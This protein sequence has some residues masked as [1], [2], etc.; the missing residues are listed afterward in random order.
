[1]KKLLNLVLFVLVALVFATSVN[2]VY[3][4]NKVQVNGVD[5][6]AVLP[7]VSPVVYVERG[8]SVN[9]MAQFANTVDAKDVRVK[10]WIGGYEFGN[11]EYTTGLFDVIAS[12]TYSKSLLLKIPDDLDATQ[13]Y[14]LHVSVYDKVTSQEVSYTLRIARQRHEL[15]FVDIIFNPGL[16]VRNDQPLFVTVRVE[17]LGNKDENDV[18]VIAAIPELGISQRTFLSDLRA[19]DPNDASQEH[20]SES[21]EA[22]FLDLSDVA[23][24][25]YNVVV[26]VEYNRGHDFIEK[27]FPLTVKEGKGRVTVKEELVVDAAQKVMDIKAGQG[28]VYKVSL[29]NLGSETQKLTLEVNGV[30]EWGTARADP[31][32]LTV[33]PNSN[34]EAF[35]FVSAKEDAATANKLFTVRVKNGNT[36]VKELQLQA[37]VNGQSVDANSSLKSGLEVGFV[38]LLI[39]LVILGIILAVNKLRSKDESE[40]SYY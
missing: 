27:I 38:V 18:R 22:L 8:D 25:N 36:V 2:A 12:T 4:F 14:T 17:N 10:A 29:A 35:V 21:S 16:T 7:A 32:S 6:I 1:M 13:D 31:S 33:E 15:N 23:S 30:D 34:M 28:A 37:N 26:K 19:N 20:N 11:I 24:G 3:T 9:I 5:M 40:Q 39:I